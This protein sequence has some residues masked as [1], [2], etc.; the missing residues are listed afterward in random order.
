MRAA[1]L[2]LKEP[3]RAKHRLSEQDPSLFSGRPANRADHRLFLLAG[4]PGAL[5]I[6]RA[7]RPLWA[8]EHL[9]RPCQFHD[10]PVGRQL[11]ACAARHRR[12]QHRHRRTLHGHRAVA[13]N[14]RRSRRARKGVLPHDD[15]HPL[16]G[17]AGRRRHVVVVH[18]QPGHGHVR[19]YPAPQRH[20]L[21]SAPERRPGHG[22]GRRGGRLETDQLQFS[23]L[24]RR[25]AGDPEIAPGSRLHRWRARVSPVLDDRFPAAGTH[26]LLPAGGQH[27]LRLF[28][29]I[30]H[31]PFG[32]RRR[33]G[34][35]HGNAGLQGL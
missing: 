21:G 12:L 33:T 15:D 3:A 26:H 5:S 11:S 13:G 28:R 24:R 32:H 35:G 22:A 25:P 7:G 20:C 30:R 29:H 9:C 10:D 6:R 31:H 14:R 23:L 1:F 18:V 2:I 19:L 16:C 34:Q 17:G 8:T 4:Q 27:R